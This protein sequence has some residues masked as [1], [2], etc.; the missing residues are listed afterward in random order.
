MRYLEHDVGRSLLV[1]HRVLLAGGPRDVVVST[2]RRRFDVEALVAARG[3]L[4]AAGVAQPAAELGAVTVAWYPFDPGL[5]L[6]AGDHAAIAG[7]EPLERLAWVPQQRVVL[8]RG[9]RVLKLDAEPARIDAAVRALAR[10]RPVVRVPDVLEVDA[11]SGAFVQERL[12]GRALGADDALARAAQAGALVAAIAGVPAD[13]LPALPAAGLLAALAGPLRLVVHAV[14]EL[15]GRVAALEQLLVEAAPEL[16]LVACH[17]DF[18]IGQLLAGADDRL[19]LVDTDT[20][21]RAPLGLDLAAYATNLMSGRDGDLEHMDAALDAAC[22][23]F[24]ARPQGLDWLVAATALRRL[25]RPLRRLKRRWPER[26]AR[27][28]G[29]AEELGRRVR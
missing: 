12:G 3:R 27:L 17:G 5:P 20:L 21:C 14:P 23:G 26:V 7:P 10:L 29:D 8:A 11:A 4:G 15:A 9:A 22:R 2:G 28:L 18:N 24:G 25:D 6:L 16:P 19:A 13:D 1:Q